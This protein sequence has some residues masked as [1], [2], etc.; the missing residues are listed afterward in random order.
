[1]PSQHSWLA[2]RVAF[3]RIGLAAIA[4]NCDT[5]AEMFA[6]LGRGQ[7]LGLAG[8]AALGLVGAAVLGRAYLGSEKSPI[9]ITPTSSPIP[10]DAAN[11]GPTKMIVVDVEGA[12]RSPGIQRLPDSARV[13]EAIDAAGGKADD[14]D[15]TPLNLAAKLVDGS[16]VYV[17]KKGG[18]DSTKIADGI[19][20]GPQAPNQYLA[21]PKAA[22]SGGRS[23]GPKHPS[24][25][26]SLNTGTK[27]QLESLPGVGPSTADKIIAYRME[28]G[29]FSSINELLAVKGIGPKKLKAMR[30]W[31]KL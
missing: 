25:P 19:A 22:G 17:P 6:H 2:A 27:A 20:G 14:A 9:V 26:V 11:Q 5:G 30:Q 3:R 15:T 18:K 13:F 16:Q 28:H 8:V 24:S 21:A 23:S 1:M 29:G 7:K 4:H 12:V 10:V 31:L